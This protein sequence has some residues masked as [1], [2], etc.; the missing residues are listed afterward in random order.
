MAQWVLLAYRLPREPSTPRIAL[1]RHLRRL[2]VAQI[3]DGLIALPL[4]ARTREQLGW[5]AADVREHGGE[6]TI[7]VGQ[8]GSKAEERALISVLREA[9][10]RD[11]DEVVRQADAASP[12]G[13]PANR[14]TLARLR[15][16]LRR[17]GLRDYFPGRARQRAIAAV[18]RLGDRIEAAS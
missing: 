8:P 16:E 5:V 9:V 2:G 6:A 14:R 17:V 13:A 15:R 3:S 7:W 10:D 12:V 4:D 1:M 11:Y 18:E